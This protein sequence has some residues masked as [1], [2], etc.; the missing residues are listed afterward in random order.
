MFIVS[1]TYV[2]ELTKVDQFV[3]EHRDYLDKQYASGVF[4]AS[5]RKEPRNGGVILANAESRAKLDVL[6]EQDPFYQNGVAKYDV[7][8]FIP[9]KT[10][11]EL[12]FLR[13]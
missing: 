4:L 13:Q 7:I 6:L 5:G 12:D 1:L 10:C 9:S 2:C 8:E 11:P 3:G